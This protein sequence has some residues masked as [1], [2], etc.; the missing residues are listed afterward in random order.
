MGVQHQG[1]RKEEV[2]RERTPALRR[3]PRIS[4]GR[5]D[6]HLLAWNPRSS[7]LCYLVTH[8]LTWFSTEEPVPQTDKLIGAAA[9]SE[10]T[11]HPAQ[12]QV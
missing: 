12:G 3:F 6:S 5:S 10:G 11:K 1:D 8:P 9:L 7:L 2:S 4:V